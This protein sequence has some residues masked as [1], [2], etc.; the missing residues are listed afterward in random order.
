MQPNLVNV[1]EF[2]FL[3]ETKNLVH[4][5]KKEKLMGHSFMQLNILSCTLPPM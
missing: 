2:S 4:M 3:R 5:E 1:K